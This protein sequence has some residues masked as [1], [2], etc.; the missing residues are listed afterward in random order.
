M[1]DYNLGR[2]HGTIRIDYDK[3]G[4]EDAREDVKEV[5]DEATKSS[6][7]IDDSTKQSTKS[8]E[9]L[10]V[11]AKKASE[12]L[13]FDSASADQLSATVKKL[14]K[15]VTAASS[16]AFAA[17]AK[18][19]AAE[20]SLAAVRQ[21]SGVAA[22]DVADAEKAVRQAQQST[23]TATQ[24]LQN[25]TD[26][27]R[28]ARERLNRIPKPPDPKVDSSQLQQ[29]IN[30]LKQIQ[31]NTAKS[32]SV[33]N[34]FSGRLRLIIGGVAILTPGIAGL[35]VSLASLAGLAGVAAGALASLAAVGGTLA[36]G[37]SGI[38]AAFK[39]AGAAAKSAGGSAGASAKAQQAAARAIEDAK[40]SL[41]SAEENL[42][43]TQED[44]A[45]SVA[46]ALKQIIEAER[47]LQAAQR[48]ALRAQESLNRARQQ[49]IRDLE[50]MQFAIRGGGL[51]ERQAVLDVKKAYEELQKILKDPTA[52]ADDIEQATINYEKQ[53]LAL[54]ETR[55][56]NERL[57]VD[58]A[59]ASA[60]GVEGSDAVVNAQDGVRDAT[61]SVVEAQE[62]LIE[63]Q[64]NVRRA[65]VDS[66]RQISDA[67][68][69]VVDA[70]RNLQEAY[71]D[72]AEAGG[73][74]ANTL[75][76]ALAH[77]SPNARAFVEEILSLKGAWDNLRRSVQDE[78]F[79]GLAKE[80]RPLANVW[81][82]LLQDGM[83]NVARGL[84]GIVMETVQYLKTVE[85]Q[86]NVANIFSNTG[87]AV[88]NLRTVLRDLLAAFLDI[89]SVG[90]DFL[91]TMA[92][93]AANA[94]AAFR[95]FISAAKESGQL[96]QWMQDAMDTANQLWELLKNLGSIIGSVFSALDQQGG[97]ALTTLTALTGQ[98]A[99]FLK[100]AEGQEALES[101]G[102][103]L[104]SISGAV[105]KVF[106][107]FLEVAADLLVA[108]EPLITAFADAAGTYL[109]G[110]LQALG[111]V[112][113][114]IADLF[115]F[116]GPA[117][118]PVIAAI[119]A[120]N[121]AVDA[122]KLVWIGLNTVM[123]ANPFLLIASA[124]IA[125]VF[126]IIEN[127]DAISAFLTDVWEG[128]K[129][130]AEAFGQHIKDRII[131]PITEAW[132]ALRDGWNAMVQ[133]LTDVWNG[134]KNKVTETWNSIDSGIK[135]AVNNIKDG[136]RDGFN[137]VVN[138]FKELPGRIGNF[139]KEMVNKAI[140]FG[141]DIISG[142]VRGLGNAARWIWDKLKEIVSNAWD[143]VLSFF[144]I[145]SP[146]K[147]AAEAGTDIVM[148]L[149][150]GIERS[151]D[152][153]VKA[154]ATMAEAVGSELTGASG[155]LATT[156]KLSANTSG[157]PDNFAMN[158]A[159]TGSGA[160]TTAPVMARGG[161]G[162]AAGRTV[163]V[164]KVDVYVQGNLDPTNPTAFRR[165]MVRLKNE[166]RDLD[167][168]Y[169]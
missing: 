78:L 151:A 42:R 6:K 64:E 103:V 95:D 120:A 109:A 104:A 158:A 128:I 3:S 7:K 156:M 84:N 143:S 4:A 150:A 33:L 69:S 39:A 88:A 37:M 163:I 155:T 113:K 169:V 8:F 75:N 47:D 54:E 116:L 91:P 34:T 60:A 115:G 55:K 20:E 74:A 72:T 124:I 14:E 66:A 162:A 30:H 119:Y 52:N 96:R 10:A 126:L 11:S 2:A 67:I 38:G 145:S 152:T 107:S 98:V 25:N 40:R 141:K 100:S 76:D 61:Q 94:A 13:N 27:L 108:L 22:K 43:R 112:L 166:L 147:L 93:D 148:G 129:A 62:S 48:D 167:K 77:L 57:G 99:D 161:D 9:E 51:D 146:S 31:A 85:A 32:S 73:G 135:N 134:I 142:I 59:A 97:G 165:T 105:G 131:T 50:D 133:F 87:A 18:L 110:A 63:A 68:Q 29:F 23:V 137:N 71:A 70:Q 149:V 117:L 83:R 86:R 139:L 127:W 168:E 80:V 1:P 65:Q 123:K 111:V 89:A 140:Q 130:K 45:R 138:F 154:A 121:K 160:L 114:P 35:G 118:G 106:L 49:A 44:A 82:P 136:I 102:K 46:E 81:F 79:A 144:G 101:L 58:S 5:G 56:A 53:K 159:L 26:A 19:Q 41:A 125:L 36:T 16:A 12:S 122:A 90:S 132:N 157:L 21:K 92:T 15:D 24:R 164:E 17:R 153:A 28:V